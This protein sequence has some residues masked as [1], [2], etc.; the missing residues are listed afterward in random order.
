M[1]LL[2]DTM[3][4]AGITPETF[5]QAVVPYFESMFVPSQNR[6]FANHDFA[7]ALREMFDRGQGDEGLVFTK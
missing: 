4:A 5:A 1:L 6:R 7:S 3:E 2:A